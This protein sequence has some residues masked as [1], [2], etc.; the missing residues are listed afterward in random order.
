MS[1]FTQKL[2]ATYAKELETLRQQ[3]EQLLKGI[4]EAEVK[5]HQ[6]TGAILGLN[7]FENQQR[8]EEAAKAVEATNAKN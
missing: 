5:I 6:Y 2:K 3:R 7:E 8:D 4:Q 1:E